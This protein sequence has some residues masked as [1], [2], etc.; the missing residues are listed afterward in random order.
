MITNQG[1]ENKLRSLH[2]PEV[3]VHDRVMQSLATIEPSRKRSNVPLQF[4]IGAVIAITVL[5][6]SGYT[7]FSSITLFNEQGV[8]TLTLRPFDQANPPSYT[9]E[10]RELAL[11]SI[12]SG[13]AVALFRR[14]GNPDQIMTAIENPVII[15]N[16]DSLRHAAGPVFRL[17]IEL[18]GLVSFLQ[19]SVQHRVG[20]PD[21]AELKKLSDEHG[22]QLATTK[23]AVLPQAT[24]V[25][26][27]ASLEGAE[28]S[29]LISESIWFKTLYTDLLADSDIRVIQVNEIEGLVR[30]VADHV[31]LNWSSSAS[32]GGLFYQISTEAKTPDAEQ[33]LIHFLN[34]LIPR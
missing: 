26:I 1:I 14:S 30:K 8:S 25:T 27:R 2:M 19:G 4:A 29:A 22:G 11:A 28:V 31:V 12:L 20:V 15:G 21:L 6:V 9:S 5:L 32:Q 23:V 34:S 3:D 7:V 24:G 13:E 33:K 17:P 10:E 18:S 16:W